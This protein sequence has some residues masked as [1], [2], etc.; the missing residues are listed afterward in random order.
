MVDL[1]IEGVLGRGSMLH[2]GPDGSGFEG[3]LGCGSM[4]TDLGLEGVFGR[5]SMLQLRLA[6]ADVGNEGLLSE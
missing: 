5:G 2:L 6:M 1:G 3:V 4:L